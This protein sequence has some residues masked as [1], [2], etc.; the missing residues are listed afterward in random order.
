MKLNLNK[1][2]ARTHVLYK[3]LK[4]EKGYSQEEVDKMTIRSDQIVALARAL[5][6]ALNKEFGSKKD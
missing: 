3:N 1:I 5:V 6:E 2:L 4:L